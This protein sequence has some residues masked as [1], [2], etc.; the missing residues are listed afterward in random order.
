MDGTYNYIND[1]STKTKVLT[2]D[3]P[4][5]FRD[6]NYNLVDYIHNQNS[7]T[8]ILAFKNF[9]LAVLFIITILSLAYLVI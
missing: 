5:E 8:M 2:V 3:A 9:L 4:N 7:K 6:L 1:I